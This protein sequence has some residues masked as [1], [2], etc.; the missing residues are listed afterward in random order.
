MWISGGG[1][2]AYWPYRT[3]RIE[4]VHHKWRLEKA[5]SQNDQFLRSDLRVKGRGI[6]ENILIEKLQSTLE[7]LKDQPIIEQFY[8]AGETGL[9]LQLGYL[10]SLDFD[11]FTQSKLR[12]TDLLFQIKKAGDARRGQLAPD[13]ILLSKGG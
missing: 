10:R 4:G 13:K 7:I 12:T 1:P 5:F 6:F 2:L 8:L 3:G 11:F 9:A